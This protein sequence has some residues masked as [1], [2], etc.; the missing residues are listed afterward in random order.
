V[1]SGFTTLLSSGGGGPRNGGGGINHQPHL[2]EREG[3][4]L[5]GLFQGGW[6]RAGAGAES[7]SV[8]ARYR[9]RRFNSIDWDL[10]KTARR[11]VDNILHLRILLYI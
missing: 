4:F 5:R 2:S 11:S 10:G 3:C 1:S 7:G 6:S 9:I 8:G